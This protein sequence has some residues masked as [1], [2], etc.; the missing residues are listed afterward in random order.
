MRCTIDRHNFTK[1]VEFVSQFTAPKSPKA[2]LENIKIVIDRDG[3][4]V[5]SSFDGEAQAEYEIACESRFSAQVLVNAALLKKVLKSCDMD[6]LEL[7]IDGEGDEPVNLI[8]GNHDDRF[9]LPN[10]RQDLPA[11]PSVSHDYITLPHGF[12][13]RAAAATIATDPESTRYCLS[14]V[15][16]KSTDIG[17]EIVATDGRRMMYSF[18]PMDTEYQG[19][20]LVPANVLKRLT[21]LGETEM[22]ANENMALFMSGNV[23]VACRI[24]EGRFPN[25]NAVM[26]STD[27]TPQAKRIIDRASLVA[28]LKRATVFSDQDNQV[29]KW[30]SSGRSLSIQAAA[31]SLGKARVSLECERE[32][33]DANFTVH[34][35]GECVREMIEASQDDT[36]ELSYFGG[37]NALRFTTGNIASIVMPL[38]APDTERV[39]EEE[40]ANA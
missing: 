7:D 13:T 10:F 15:L 33:G 23:K 12:L 8:I 2:V 39:E 17:L 29:T 5:L 26:Q 22:A 24:I 18:S 11:L 6:D 9:S 36:V 3:S 30:V 31:A 16:I 40:E 32:E 27:G 34:I 28:T 1:A 19:E 37:T 21:K 35:N 14:G 25:Y 38:T 20:W 4:A